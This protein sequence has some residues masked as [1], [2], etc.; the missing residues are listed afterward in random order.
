MARPATL[1]LLSVLLSAVLVR[2]QLKS[3]AALSLSPEMIKE[4]FEQGLK[5]HGIVDI[6]KQ[7]P[8]LNAMQDQPA[9]GI[10]LI[11]G[12]VSSILKNIVWLKVTSASVPQLQVL[13]NSNNQEIVIK[14]P[15]DMVI[16]FNTPLV[17]TIVEMHVESDTQITLAVE[18]VN[19]ED[20]LVVKDCGSSQGGL[21]ISLLGS[22]SFMVNTLSNKIINLLAP[23][24]PKLVKNELCP[25]MKVTFK[26]MIMDFLVLLKEPISVGPGTL[27]LYPLSTNIDQNAIQMQLGA[28]ILG[29]QGNVTKVFNETSVS[30][31]MPPLNG[32]PFSFAMKPEV[33]GAAIASL[34]RPEELM[35][36]LDH[37]LPELSHKLKE[38]IKAISEKAAAELGSTN[39]VKVLLQQPP[40]FFL[41]NGLAKV[42]QL[43]VLEIFPTNQAR[44]PL[45]T[46]GIEASSDVQ[47]NTEGDQLTTSFSQV[48]ADRVRLMNSA[49]GLFN[50]E[51]LKPVINELIDAILLPDE[52]GKLRGGIPLS[53][54][55]GLGFNK[56]SWS[57]IKDALVI[58][59]AS[60]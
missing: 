23:A 30:M 34:I 53:L 54:V 31:M 59:P 7:L 58:T 35:I 2:A 6:L 13:P 20:R 56:A 51:L 60:S 52:N 22:F 9:G 15:L 18:N 32:S 16:G 27:E 43:I 4:K 46:L 8:L 37:V 33:V 49:I 39:I 5:D 29:P 14:V 11:G 41:E 55:K 25:L 1:I 12:L 44:R 45:F 48:S 42:A 40:E 3:P 24:L 17:K 28:K 21:R 38:S 26:D 19:G 47:F 10:P 57:L 50:A 36:L